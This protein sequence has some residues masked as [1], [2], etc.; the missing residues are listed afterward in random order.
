MN[1]PREGE[2][3]IVRSPFEAIVM[4][5]W[6]APYTGGAPKRIPA[7]VSFVIDYDPPDMA[8]AIGVRPE[9]SARWEPHLVDAAERSAAKYAGYSIS[10]PFTLLAMHCERVR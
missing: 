1:K 6:E 3:Y 5:H 8:S 2:R 9:D 10:I 4:T 7:G